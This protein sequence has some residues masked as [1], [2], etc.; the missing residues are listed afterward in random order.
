MSIPDII[1]VRWLNT[2]SHLIGAVA[3]KTLYGWKAY[4][5]VAGSNGANYDADLA[6]IYH[7]G[8]KLYEREAR[9]FFPGITYSYES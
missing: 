5:G 1:G 9:A 2:P 3:I 4:L 7:H 8:A 6:A